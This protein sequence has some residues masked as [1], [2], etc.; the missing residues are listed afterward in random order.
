MLNAIV[1]AVTA[2]MRA[3]TPAQGGTTGG[4]THNA[5]LTRQSVEKAGVADARGY[6]TRQ[7]AAHEPKG[8]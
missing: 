1:A 8:G 3:A 4:P 2:Q 5:S 6:T 7:Q